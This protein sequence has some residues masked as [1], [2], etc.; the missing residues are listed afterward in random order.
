[1]KLGKSSFINKFSKAYP[2]KSCT[3]LIQWFEENKK[4]AQP[5]GTGYDKLDNLE[6]PIHIKNDNDF[7]GLKGT[8]SECIIK[9]KKL[10]P[11]I[12]Q[13]LTRWALSPIMQLTK[14]QPGK[15]YQKIHCENDGDSRF[16]NRAF[17]WMIFLN[18]IKKGG[19][20]KFLY[21]NIIAHPI[22]GDFYVWPAGWTHFHQGINAPEEEK[23]IISGWIDYLK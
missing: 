13:Y 12:D 23:Y 19:G 11:E 6:I 2:Q 20:T 18:D 8:L 21:Q 7:Y 1:M 5:G 10:Y 17:A 16:L 22:A 9:L 15:F 14:Y 4:I 3:N